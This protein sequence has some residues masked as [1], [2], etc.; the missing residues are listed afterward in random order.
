MRLLLLRSA[1]QCSKPNMH[2]TDTSCMS[3]D[4]IH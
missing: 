3:V 1:R 4:V 2:V